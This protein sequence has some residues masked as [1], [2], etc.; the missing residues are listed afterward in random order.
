MGAFHLKFSKNPP[1]VVAFADL[2]VRSENDFRP[3][4]PDAGTAWKLVAEPTRRLT[5]LVIILGSLH[6]NV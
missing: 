4:C 5:P 6:P 3:S 2:G 1:S